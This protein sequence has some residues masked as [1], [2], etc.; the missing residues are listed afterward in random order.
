[1]EAI[2]KHSTKVQ[3]KKSLNPMSKSTR[4]ELT[5]ETKSLKSDEF[6]QNCVF[7]KLVSATVNLVSG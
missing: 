4:S 6:H 2:Q 5:K 3:K 7:N 1:M